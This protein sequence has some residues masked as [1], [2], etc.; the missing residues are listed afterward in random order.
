MGPSSAPGA[1]APS[2]A[3]VPC[4]D[5]YPDLALAAVLQLLSRFPARRSPALAHTIA[6]HFQVIAADPRVPESLRACA[7]RLIADWQAYALL[8]EFVEE[9][10]PSGALH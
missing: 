7:D 9:G 5:T 8:G 2:A 3:H 10:P 6:C 4:Y 1:G